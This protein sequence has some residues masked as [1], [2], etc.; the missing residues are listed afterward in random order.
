MSPHL[1]RD[2]AFTDY[3]TSLLLTSDVSRVA[4]QFT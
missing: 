4:V 2:V 1:I 3:A